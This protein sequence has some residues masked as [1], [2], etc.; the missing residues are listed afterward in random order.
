M[1]GEEQL[2]DAA[3]VPHAGLQ[4]AKGSVAVLTVLYQPERMMDGCVG[5]SAS[6]GGHLSWGRTSRA[7]GKGSLAV[8]A[9]QH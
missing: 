9:A 8:L 5:S 4:L 2:G 1:A 7:L 3:A 6:Q